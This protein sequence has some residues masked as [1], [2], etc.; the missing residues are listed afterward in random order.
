MN[1]KSGISLNEK[2]SVWNS[3][4]LPSSRRGRK[5]SEPTDKIE[6][7]EGEL[8]ASRHEIGSASID[9]EFHKIEY[10]Q[11]KDRPACIIIID[12]RLVSPPENTIERAQMEFQFAKDDEQNLAPEN[13]IST[14]ITKEP[15]SRVFAPEDIE[16]MPSQST[17]TVHHSIKPKIEGLTFKIDT[18]GG[19]GQTT[20]INN[21]RWQVVGRREKHNNIYDTF[22]WKIFQ[23][24]VSQDS[25]PRKVRLGMIAFHRYQPFWVNVSINGRTRQKHRRLKATQEKR[26]FTPPNIEDV[27]H[28]ILQEAMVESL[29]TKQNLRIRDI[30]PSR[31]VEGRTMNL[32]DTTEFSGGAGTVIDGGGAV[33]DL[34]SIRDVALTVD[35]PTTTIDS[36]MCN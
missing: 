19:G 29:V 7:I 1:S 27:G 4:R 8:A 18:G 21:H 26:W 20:T 15:I 35:S 11:F 6:A 9:C 33:M 16:G 2:K 22:G 14:Q 23:N 10:G 36:N 3:I 32:I 24:E 13:H 28:H 30:A 25:V 5:T 31:L 34:L 12:V 17:K